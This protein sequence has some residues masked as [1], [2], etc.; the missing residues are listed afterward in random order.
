MDVKIEP[1]SN[2]LHVRMSGNFHSDAPFDCHLQSIGRVCAGGNYTRLLI[3]A[4]EV[5][6][7]MEIMEAYHQGEDI[8][9]VFAPS[10][11]RIA[12]ACAEG[13]MSMLTFFENVIVNRG[14]ILRV[15][16]DIDEATEWLMT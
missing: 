1:R 5:T 3:D 14:A 8:A 12:I 16:A 4:R 15:F 6:G 9:R 10:N 2:Y 7:H 11:V 13:H